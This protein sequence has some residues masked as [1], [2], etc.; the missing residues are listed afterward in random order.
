MNVYIVTKTT[1]PQD[2]RKTKILDV[3]MNEDDAYALVEK[4]KPM[5]GEWDYCEVQ[6]WHA[7]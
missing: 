1:G 3:L 2:S 7:R 5:M 6:K 4:M